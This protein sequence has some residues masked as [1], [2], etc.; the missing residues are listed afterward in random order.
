[1][2][3][4]RLGDDAEAP[5]DLGAGGP[6]RRLAMQESPAKRVE[7]HGTSSTHSL[8]ASGSTVVFIVRTSN[9]EP[10]KG[11]RPDNRLVEHHAHGVPVACRARLFE[12]LLRSH[13][14]CGAHRP[15]GVAHLFVDDARDLGR[16]AE[17]EDDDATLGRDEHVRGLDVAMDPPRGVE[18]RDALDELAHGGAQA[19]EVGRRLPLVSARAGD[20]RVGRRVVRR[21]GGVRARAILVPDTPVAAAGS[22]G[23]R[24]SRRDSGPRTWD[25][26]SVPR[27]SSIV[28][29]TRSEPV[30]TNSCKRTRFGW[31]TS[32]SVRN[33]CLKR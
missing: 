19:I 25:A 12:G 31:S 14:R 15:L 4:A 18:R 11:G 30:I 29:K 13:V 9:T 8:G 27:T 2:L 26:K 33:S 6:H 7:L 23:R 5:Q 3:G 22:A 20:L 28:K 17:V 16:D 10:L 21:L 24:E 1:M 32:A